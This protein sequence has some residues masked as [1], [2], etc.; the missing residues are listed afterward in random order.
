MSDRSGAGNVYIRNLDKTIDTQELHDTFEVFGK[1]HSCLVKTDEKGN[2]L[3]YGFVHFQD[4]EVA[5][6]VIEEVDGMMI[7]DKK[8]FVGPWKS[9]KERL[10]E[11]G[12][13]KRFLNVFIKNLPEDFTEDKLRTMVSLICLR[14]SSGVCVS[15]CLRAVLSCILAFHLLIQCHPSLA[16]LNPLERLL[17]SSLS[18]MMTI[19]VWVSDL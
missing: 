19:S 8:V 16:S 4:P 17:V 14:V 12:A 10:E 3:G 11:H 18:W 6:T 2:S 13:E 1:I 7:R 15:V 9:H 5:K